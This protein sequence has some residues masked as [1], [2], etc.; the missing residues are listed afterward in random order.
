MRLLY[1]GPLWQGST[2]LQRLNAF[3]SVSGLVVDA[4]DSG[5]RVGSASFMDRIRHRVRLPADHSG[6]NQRLPMLARRFRP[7]VLFVDSTRVLT[8]RTLQLVRAFGARRLAFY[9]PDDVSAPHNS[10]RQLERCDAEWDVF[11]T[12]KTFNVA[13]LRARGVRRPALVGNAFDPDLHSPLTVAE[14]TRDFEAFDAVFVGTFE[15]DRA[16]SINCLVEAG[17]SVVVYGNG[18]RAGRINPDVELR[19]AVYAR[20]YTTALHS[21]RVA[22][23]FLRKLNRDRVTT[24]SVEIPA[25]GRPMV[26]EKTPEHDE[27][28]VD[29]REYVSF[30]NDAEL[31]ERVRWVLAD[32]DVRRS[33]A[34]SGRSRCL[35]AGYSTHARARQMISVLQEVS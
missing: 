2:A 13:E 22:L 9:S 34:S 33:I 23:G 14:A 1:V 28:F 8:V 31:V 3:R 29:M 32:D 6:L 26:A 18:W 10:S 27:M 20:A 21:G 25:A 11:F 30:R 12:T 5:E 7:D 19:P 35:T 17:V 4:I 16:T 24:R 15:Q